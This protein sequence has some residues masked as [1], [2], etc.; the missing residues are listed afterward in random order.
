MTLTHPDQSRSTVWQYPGESSRRCRTAER[1]Q[2]TTALLLRGA[3]I[4]MIRWMANATAAR[5]T[6]LANHKTAEHPIG[7]T[8]VGQ[9]ERNQDQGSDQCE[10]KAF[11]LGSGLLD[12]ERRRNYHRIETD[13][14]ADEA[15]DKEPKRRK[16]GLQILL[17]I[18]DR[19]EH[20]GQRQHDQR[21]GHRDQAPRQVK[22][23]FEAGRILERCQ[24]AEQ[25][26]QAQR[27][28]TQP[29]DITAHLHLKIVSIPEQKGSTRRCKIRRW[30]TC[31]RERFYWCG[32]TDAV[33]NCLEYSWLGRPVRRV[34]EDITST[35]S[36]LRITASF[37]HICA[38]T[39]RSWETIR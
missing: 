4:Q 11:V 12:A 24:Q 35:I 29:P 27:R 22:P 17:I 14:D 6:T 31:S 8:R 39:G 38:T 1:D 18:Q 34:S 28:G 21:N 9:N 10:S 16:E 33:S 19:K 26:D 37:L 30:R 13:A 2:Y 5:P 32:A 25:P 15:D 20:P 23:T 7:I 36:P 3:Y